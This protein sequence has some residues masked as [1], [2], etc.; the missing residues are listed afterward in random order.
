MIHAPY[1]TVGV[2][3]YHGGAVI[4]ESLRSIQ[5]QSRRD[6]TVI[7]SLDGPQPASE[8]ACRPFLKDSRFHLVAQPR[9]SAGR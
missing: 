4:E 5:R 9:G 7:I 6:L 2:P 3:V 1:V 8:E